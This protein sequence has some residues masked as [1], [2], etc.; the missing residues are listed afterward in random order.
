MKSHACMFKFNTREAE[1]GVRFLGIFL[2]LA[3]VLGFAGCGE[4]QQEA[5]N[6]PPQTTNKPDQ[7]S[8]P[9]PTDQQSGPPPTDQQ[10]GPPP[11]N[12]QS[13]PP[14]TNQQSDPLTTKQQADAPAVTIEATPAGDE[15]TMVQLRATLTGGVYD[16]A[17]EYFWQVDNGSLDDPTSATPIWTR[18]PVTTDINH[19]VRLTVTVRGTGTNAQSGTSDTANASRRTLVRYTT[20]DLPMADAPTVTINAIATGEE[21]T[22][23][24]LQATLAGGVYDSTPEYLWQ[25]DGGRLDDSAS[26]TPIWTRPTVTSNMNHTVRLTV[27]VRGTGTNAQSRSSDTARASRTTLTTPQLPVAD[28]PTVTINAIATGEENT[29]VRLSASLTG[30]TYDGNLK[31]D[32]RVDGGRLDDS[33][34]ATPT[35]T[36]PLVN[37]D[38]NYTVRLT[39]TVRGTGT[40]AQSG[41]SNTSNASRS[42]SVR[43]RPPGPNLVVESP[44]IS[45]SALVSREAFTLSVIVHNRGDQPSKKTEIRYYRSLD[46]TIDNTDSWLAIDKVPALM[47]GETS[48]QSDDKRTALFKLGTYY[49]G[50]CIAKSNNCSTAVRVDVHNPDTFIEA[51]TV[52]V[53][54][55]ANG[56][57][58]TTAQLSATLTG[59]RYFLSSYQ[60]SVRPRGGSYVPLPASG[61]TAEWLRPYVTANTQYQ[62]RLVVYVWKEGQAPLQSAASTIFTTVTDLGNEL[63][64]VKY[65]GYDIVHAGYQNQLHG[66]ES[67]RLV[68]LHN[69][70]GDRYDTTQFSWSVVRGGGRIVP[71]PGRTLNDRIAVYQAPANVSS[72]F[73]ATIRATVTYDGDGTTA[74]AG[75][76]Q[77]SWKNLELDV[78]P[79]R[80]MPVND[81]RGPTTERGDEYADGYA[82]WNGGQDV[83]ITHNPYINT[84]P[85]RTI[86]YSFPEAPFTWGSKAL[87][88]LFRSDIFPID[89][90]RARQYTTEGLRD[91]FR[92]AFAHWE[93]YLN[94]RFREVADSTTANLVIGRDNYELS[95]HAY[96]LTNGD[97]NSQAIAAGVRHVRLNDSGQFETP[98]HEIGHVLGLGH[99]HTQGSGANLDDAVME[100]LAHGRS[101]SIPPPRLQ[102]PADIIAAQHIWG[103]ASGAPRTVP[104]VPATATLTYDQENDT[105]TATWTDVKINGGTDVT[106]WTVD[107][108]LDSNPADTD[109]YLGGGTIERTDTITNAST[110][111]AT[112][113]NPED[114]DWS[115]QIRA[116]NAVGAGLRKR[117]PG[118]GDGVTVN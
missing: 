12:R 80:T 114:G 68:L 13:G 75:Q 46:A 36:R 30:G 48:P 14:P 56:G 110:R 89:E 108:L 62:I 26:A 94:I 23:V 86:T 43:N 73:K 5:G 103:P 49:Y 38:T 111:S 78:L 65:R 74:L 71:V 82:F 101:S 104:D 88:P 1:E 40:N 8:G 85:G 95:A 90:T 57:E 20:S 16:G 18:P 22:T 51:P 93:Q 7:Q 4:T 33:A 34:S 9:P 112:Y 45:K 55:V 69:P 102:F 105:L 116:V 59:G 64:R 79:N 107:W 66:G 50:A 52:T 77:T 3:I 31:Y 60:W 83:Q 58:G 84:T 28:A 91:N 63:P 87:Q 109:S 118:T 99:P 32:W 10:S 81:R 98:L 19:T 24:R 2:L 76:S 54:P 6:Q 17:P 27:T 100:Y 70:I 42:A 11:T 37:S 15:S 25:V 35:W 97:S 61:K 96:T 53:N 21:N 41:T 115:V 47:P 44:S 92:Q 29:T 67:L 39:V 106:G 117:A 72:Q 113:T